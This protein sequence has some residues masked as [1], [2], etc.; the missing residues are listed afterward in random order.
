VIGLLKVSG[1]QRA[2]A[3]G[4]IATRNK[5]AVVYYCPGPLHVPGSAW[6]IAVR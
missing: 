2:I 5:I 3:R 1:T 6:G 4:L